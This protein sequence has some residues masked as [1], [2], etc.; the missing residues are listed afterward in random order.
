M[1]TVGFRWYNDVS[2]KYDPSKYY[3]N[4]CVGLDT[5]VGVILCLTMTNYS[6]IYE[7]SN[8][9]LNGVIY[10]VNDLYYVYWRPII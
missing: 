4:Y 7:K 8:H 1:D 10:L 2:G 9:T 6:H 5:L 3:G